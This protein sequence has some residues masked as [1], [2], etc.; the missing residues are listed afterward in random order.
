[1]L[2]VGWRQGS[3]RAG[4]RRGVLPFR[5]WRCTTPVGQH[6][7]TS[8]RSRQPRLD[9][10]RLERKVGPLARKFGWLLA[11]AGL[12]LQRLAVQVVCE[13]LLRH[14][15]LRVQA[16]QELPYLRLDGEAVW[17]V[18]VLLDFSSDLR[19]LAALAEIDEAFMVGKEVQVAFLNVQNVCQVHA[20]EGHT[21]WVDGAQLFLVLAA[22]IGIQ[23]ERLVQ[24]LLQAALDTV[25]C[26]LQPVDAGTGHGTGDGKDAREVVELLEHQH[27]LQ[28]ARHHSQPLLVVLSL[29]DAAL[30]PE[31]KVR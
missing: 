25:E 5:G 30:Q 8:R 1:M 10:W 19:H 31:G 4:W 22:V 27:H 13:L 11:A 9:A 17:L 3:G 14:V 15:L 28:H 21:G 7:V 24:R 6:L 26:V 2:D 12:N 16:L 29:H 23:V 18:L 20:E